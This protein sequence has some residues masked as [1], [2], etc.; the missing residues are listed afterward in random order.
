MGSDDP[1]QAGAALDDQCQQRLADLARGQVTGP[2][3][4]AQVCHDNARCELAR[5]LD[6]DM[7]GAFR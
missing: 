5:V 4:G 2:D 1:P 7:Q 3:L 6:L